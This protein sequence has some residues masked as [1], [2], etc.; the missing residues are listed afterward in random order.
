MKKKKV[1]SFLASGRGKNFA[2]V[3]KKINSGYI[4]AQVGILICDKP[5][6]AVLEKAKKYKIDFVFIDPKSFSSKTEYEKEIVKYL[7]NYNTDYIIAAGFMRLLSPYIINIYQNRIINIHPSLLPS[8]P[9]RDAQKQALE[10]GAKITGC[11]VHFIDEGTDTGPIILQH[12]VKIDKNDNLQKL[13]EKILKDEHKILI[14]SI[15]LLCEN[16]IE[17]IGRKVV[18]H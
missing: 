2:A 12:M 9:G 18:I 7:E 3:I 5:D 15:K 6:A 10:Y 11:T 16:R 14:K 17:I 1:I 13:S 8:F 4:P